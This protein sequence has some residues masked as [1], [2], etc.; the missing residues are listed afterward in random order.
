MV[1][2]QDSLFNIEAAKLLSRCIRLWL[3]VEKSIIM[4]QVN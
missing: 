4:A 2:S 3:I 1:C